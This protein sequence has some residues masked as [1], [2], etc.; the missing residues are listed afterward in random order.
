MGTYTHKKKKQQQKKNKQKKQVQLLLS[1]SL[2]PTVYNTL[3]NFSNVLRMPQVITCHIN[4]VPRRAL[5][6]TGQQRQRSP[7]IY[8]GYHTVA[9]R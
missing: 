3:N 5:F 9:Q 2:H 1:R 8:R 6:P 7:T 4:I